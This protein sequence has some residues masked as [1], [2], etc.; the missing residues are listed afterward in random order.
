[1]VEG[2]GAEAMIEV[3]MKWRAVAL[4][5]QHGLSRCLHNLKDGRKDANG[6]EQ[7]A[8][9]GAD[10]HI[11]GAIGEAA[12][13]QHYGIEW[14]P[15]EFRRVDV[16]GFE[17][18]S[19]DYKLGRLV[20][21]EGDRIGC[22]YILARLHKLP[23]VVLVGWLAG[24]DGMRKDWWGECNPARPNGRP[25]FWVPNAELHDMEELRA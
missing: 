6:A 2:L 19:T 13:A 14:K 16:G 25:A 10:M 18:R 20:L 17:V 24:E 12:V 21:H 4:A 1:V 8:G 23:V 22:P 11:M 3:A 15:M 7:V 5:A 9:I